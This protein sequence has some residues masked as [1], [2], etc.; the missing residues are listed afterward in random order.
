[1]TSTGKRIRLERKKLGLSLEAFAAKV[2]VSLLTLQR[3][4]TGKTSPSVALLAEIAKNLNKSIVSFVEDIE[5][6]TIFIKDKDQQVIL[7]PTM[8]LRVIG[9]E[10]MVSNRIIITYGEMDK[11][12]TIDGH[13]HSGIEWAYV[14]EGKTEH[15]QNG[16]SI[17]MVAGDS[18]SYDAGVEHSVTA[19]EK[20]KF[21][22]V[23]L[24]NSE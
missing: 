10:N 9:P 15:I 2:G 7:T 21:F 22:G 5:K 13:S 8:K 18:I 19:L 14:L 3:I 12:K 24:K 4:E 1:M 23:Y 6:P 11:G 16:K 20:T 17:I